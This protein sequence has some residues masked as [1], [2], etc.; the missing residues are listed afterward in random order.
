MKSTTKLSTMFCFIVVGFLWI[1]FPVFAG[2]LAKYGGEFMATGG[3]A[4]PLG[5]G[6]AYTALS[7][8]AYAI[9]WNP[10]GLNSI[11]H[12]QLG[13]MHSERFAG[14]VDYDVAGIALP[15]PDNSVIGFGI[16]RLGVN[17]IPFTRLENPGEPISEDNRV[18]VDKIV[19]EGEYA[20]YAAKSGQ[21]R[22]WSW[23]VAPK[24]VFKHIG[25]EQQAYGLGF[26]AGILGRPIEKLPITAGL[27]VRDVLGTVIAWDTGHTEVIVSTIRFGIAAKIN[28][29]A[30]EAKIIPVADVD[31][32]L[33]AIGESNAF[34]SHIGLEYLIR[35][36]IG[37]RIGS[38]DGELTFG[39]GLNLNP[40]SI[41]Y[42]FIDH[43]ALGETHRVSIT[44]HWNRH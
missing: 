39:G 19:T 34:A 44:A 4:R 28:L 3:G 14:E 15:Q 42:A 36:S 17:N 41:D 21:F 1:T 2:G 27:A 6:G 29:P 26:D 18:E 22:N 10:A 40:L 43:D 24:L 23:G 32:R 7:E 20:F 33:E 11:R 37:L 9:F 5:M 8:D 25:S 12:P 30:L 35:D 38:D 31:Y 16:I 13:L